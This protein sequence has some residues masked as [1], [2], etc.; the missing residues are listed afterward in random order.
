MRAEPKTVTDG[1]TKCRVRN[2][3]KKSRI[4]R[5]RVKNS[6]K[7]D[8]GPSRKISS[9]GSEGAVVSVELETSG[10]AMTES[11]VVCTKDLINLTGN[12]R[13]AK[14]QNLPGPCGCGR[15][16]CSRF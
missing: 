6:A 16:H 1:P 15:K 12:R 9:S 11:S 13:K 2:P 4:T 8:R 7:R 10:I 3:R 14:R 5:K